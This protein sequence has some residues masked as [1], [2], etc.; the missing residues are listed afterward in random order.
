MDDRIEQVYAVVGSRFTWEKEGD[1]DS[2]GA[3]RELV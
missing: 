2:E 3:E 1:G